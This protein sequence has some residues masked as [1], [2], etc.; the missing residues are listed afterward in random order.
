MNIRI[1][2]YIIQA[3]IAHVPARIRWAPWQE[4][5]S[6]FGFS[7]RRGSCTVVFVWPWQH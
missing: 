4:I 3:G 6:R 5:Q 7:S 2:E 1:F